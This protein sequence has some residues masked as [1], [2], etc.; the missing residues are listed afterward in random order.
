[1]TDHSFHSQGYLFFIYVS[2]RRVAQRDEYDRQRPWGDAKRW[3]LT[4][5]VRKKSRPSDYKKKLQVGFLWFL[6]FFFIHIS[7]GLS[8]PDAHIFLF[9]YLSRNIILIF[10]TV[11]VLLLCV[12][13]VSG[14]ERTE[15]KIWDSDC[16]FNFFSL[17]RS[18]SGW[19]QFDIP[20]ILSIFLFIIMI[21]FLEVRTTKMRKV[22]MSNGSFFYSLSSIFFS[23]KKLL[24]LLIEGWD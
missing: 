7:S 23:H 18:D 5:Q 13:P 21:I 10:Y 11:R 19:V 4:H 1:M 22:E 17:L 8:L 16:F 2:K 9:H 3:K 20:R 6:P 15:K 14:E 12:D 24:L